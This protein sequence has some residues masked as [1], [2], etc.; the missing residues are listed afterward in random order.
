MAVVK[1]HDG[2]EALR[3]LVVPL[4]KG[5]HRD[6]SPRAP[7]RRATAGVPRRTGDQENAVHRADSSYSDCSKRI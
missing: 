5:A 1:F 3:M 7:F 4:N 6:A 2:K